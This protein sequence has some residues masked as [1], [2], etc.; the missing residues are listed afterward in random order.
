MGTK[1]LKMVIGGLIAF[2][3][4]VGIAWVWVS[5]VHVTWDIALLGVIIWNQGWNDIYDSSAEPGKGSAL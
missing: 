1:V 5:L 4:S 3:T 2:G